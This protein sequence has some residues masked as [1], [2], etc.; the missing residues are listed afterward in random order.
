MGG[1]YNVA[2][3]CSRLHKKERNIAIV[4]TKNK[5]WKRIVLA[6]TT[7][8]LCAGAAFPV[9]AEET[10]ETRVTHVDSV[11][12]TRWGDTMVVYRGRA[13]TKQN[14]WGV[15]VTVGADGKV[16][17]I[18]PGGDVRGKDLAIPEGGMVVSG[19]G[20][21]AT[22]LE[23]NIEVGD[24]VVFDAYGSRVLVSKGEVDP[25][26]E[27][28]LTFT[29]YNQPRYSETLII[30]NE[31]GKQTETNGYGYEVAVGSDGLILEAGGNNR[32]VP[33]GG[34]VI[35]AIEPADRDALKTYF[36]PGA[37]C[38]VKGMTIRVSYNASMIGETVSTELEK[39]QAELETAQS[40]LRLVDYAAVR[41][42]ADELRSRKV[43]TLEERDAALEEI[44][45]L[46]RQLIEAR[47]VEVRSTWY[48]PLEKNADEVKQTVAKMKEVGLN[49]LCLGVTASML[50]LTRDFPLAPRAR[51]MTYDLLGAYVEACKEAEIELIVSVAVFSSA[52]TA[53][54]GQWLTLNNHGQVGD[55]AFFS[56]ANE[57][58][59]EYFKSLI[60]YIVTHYDID[61]FQYDYIRYPYFDGATDYGF[62]EGTK[63]LFE[64]ETGLSASVV[65][66]IAVSLYQHP[67]WNDWVN[68]KT[69]L[70]NRR[71][72]EF[73]EVVRELRPDLYISAAVASS[74]GYCQDSSVWLRNQWVDGIYP[75][76]YAE[77]IMESDTTRF[78]KLITD[79]TFLV[80]G[81]GAYLSLSENEMFIQTRD[82]ALYG[83]DGIAYF[84]WGAYIEHE[85][86]DAL[87]E[88]L[89]AHSPALSCT[90]AE[91]ESVEELL[92][93]AKERFE[94]YFSLNGEENKE[95]AQQA[96]DECGTDAA[97]L[98]TELQKLFPKQEALLQDVE[99]AA[100]IQRF[101]RSEYKG[102]VEILPVETSKPSGDT[103]QTESSEDPSSSPEQETS[104]DVSEGGSSAGNM[105][106]WIGLG[107]SLACVAAAAVLLVLRRKKK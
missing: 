97:K 57:E 3:Q 96:F 54:F 13:T 73:S 94:L 30:Y 60:T 72:Q 6:V 91:Q 81:N 103:S 86:A 19:T 53:V 93:V 27:T 71:V 55:E 92:K 18:I 15:N 87:S 24:N 82:S 4:K 45:L 22:W 26:Y 9:W 83:G 80:M 35:S 101:S 69:N 107:V 63:Q 7:L 31:G 49:Q 70:I 40:Q 100:R 20:V 52:D 41:A 99:L 43:E 50:K 105:K 46:K 51:I 58:F 78:Q 77:G 104:S 29:G 36:I 67:H 10:A 21:K 16:I 8:G 34:Y 25:F 102:T 106:L 84:E 28:T 68:F 64:K 95:A 14:Q 39:L 17:E 59:I 47:T 89:F 32:T 56:P 38:E 66:E 12:G 90:Y 75:M 5:F 98:Y 74:S 88:M 33:M 61:G 37:R 1:K 76:S 48:V 79:S 65:D 44:E 11:N 23:E 2:M 85:Y 42:K 62:D